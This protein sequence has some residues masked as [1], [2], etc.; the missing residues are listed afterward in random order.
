M[1]TKVKKQKKVKIT[2]QVA[3]ENVI[4]LATERTAQLESLNNESED[5]FKAFRSLE[6]IN[7]LNKDLFL[8]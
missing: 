2:T 8:K 6:I 5:F 1:K 3:L 7:N 4:Q